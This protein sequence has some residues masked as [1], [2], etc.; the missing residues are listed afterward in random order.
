MPPYFPFSGRIS[1]SLP[2]AILPW[3]SASQVVNPEVHQQEQHPAEQEDAHEADSDAKLVRKVLINYKRKAASGSVVNRLASI[4]NASSQS[5]WTM[6]RAAAEMCEV[7][8]RDSF[9]KLCHWDGAS[10]RVGQWVMLCLHVR[11][12]ETPQKLRIR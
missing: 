6:L 10:K 11:Y 7:S 1:A 9:H 3:L 2:D 5:A 12:D 8:Q 4:L